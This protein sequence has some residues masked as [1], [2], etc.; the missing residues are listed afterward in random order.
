MLEE[1][2]SVVGYEGLYEVS[3]AGRVR[4][5]PRVV[6][7]RS[8][9]GGTQNYPVKGGILAQSTVR[10]G[11]KQVSLTYA[12]AAI[13]AKVHQLVCAAFHGP[14]PSAE[15]IVAHNNG[16]RGDNTKD[17][18][19]WSTPADNTLD[20]TCH[21]TDLRGSQLSWAKLSE[22][23]IPKI[24]ALRREGATLAAIAAKFNVDQSNIAL[25]VT[26]QTWKHVT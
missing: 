6:V 17:N 8:R 3:S 24:R 10:E 16:R 2:C 18:V 5:L 14:A 20:R 1:W 12:G 22:K 15:H 26:H 7:G 13:T 11:Y 25:I 21:G 23:D 9:W 19:R 4:S